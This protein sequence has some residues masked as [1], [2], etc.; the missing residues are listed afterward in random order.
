MY[1]YRILRFI[2]GSYLILFF[3]IYVMPRLHGGMG[4]RP[5]NPIWF[6]FEEILFYQCTEPKTLASKMLFYSNL[7]PFYQDDKSGCMQY[8]WT[9]E[10]D[11]QL[12]LLIPFLVMIYQKTSLKFFVFLNT[13][14]L[15]IG[16]YTS[17]YIAAYYELTAGVFS[18]NNHNMLSMWMMKPYCKLHLFFLGILSAILYEEIKKGTVKK[19][20]SWAPHLLLVLGLVGMGTSALIAFPR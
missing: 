18:M 20:K 11:L 14:F 2:P 19:S 16:V 15:L 6:S 7:Y 9:L 17:K 13:T 8:T 4:D 12:Y 10:C 1:G 3:G 5:G